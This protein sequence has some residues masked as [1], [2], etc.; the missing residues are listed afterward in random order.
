VAGD[1]SAA[2]SGVGGLN[3]KGLSTIVGTVLRP[4]GRKG[5]R[6]QLVGQSTQ[7]VLLNLS[8][9]TFGF[10]TSLVLTRLLGR[11]G[12]GIYVYA[13]AWPAL[14]AIGAQ[15]GYGHVLVRNIAAYTVREEWGLVRGII[16]RS[17]RAVVAASVVLAL[18]AG[19]VGWLFVGHGQP[20]LRQSFFIA[21]LL[22]PASALIALREAVLRGFLRV[23]LGRLSE[24]VVVPAVLLTCLAGLYLTSDGHLSPP[25]AV[26]AAVLAAAAGLF[27][28]TIFVARATPPH[29]RSAT[30]RSDQAAWSR[31]ARSLVA[32]SGLQVVNLQM[33]VLLL[34]AMRTVDATAVFS[35]ALRWA[36]LVSFLQSAV[37]FPLAPAIARL[38]ATGAQAQLQRLISKASLGV[39]ILSA[40]IAGG[41]VL[42]GDH[43][44]ALFGDQFRSGTTVLSILVLGE[45]INVASGFVGVILINTGQERT[46]F[47]VAAT[48]TA[49]KILLTAALIGRFGLN[50]AAVG[51]AVGLAAQNICL[52]ISVWRRLRLYAPG[53]GGGR[54]I[55]AALH[56]AHDRPPTPPT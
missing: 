45:L 4:G 42:F 41:L 19:V 37:I 26:A 49:T 47:T 12:Y 53:I 2:R 13:L 30:A 35:I 34:G 22:V 16:R 36:G 33:T 54:F 24:T 10:I 50:G 32:V 25:Q 6:A 14:L 3:R 15:L 43:A 52:A 31:S 8:A 51:Q 17:Q 5:L 44:L 23:A 11:R 56:R 40:P 46:L 7:T 9:M 48:L 20:L 18:G 55:R 27:T 1:P 39:L 21:L 28:G 29:V 38:H